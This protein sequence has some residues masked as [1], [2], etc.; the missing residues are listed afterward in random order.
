MR[1]DKNKINKVCV[2]CSGLKGDLFMKIP[3]IEAIK[4]DM[5]WVSISAVV[6]ENNVNVLINHPDITEVLPHSR[7]KKN[8]IKYLINTFK[9]IHELRKRK[10]DLTIN[11]YSGGISN[12]LV[13]L[14]NARYRIGFNHI[15]A[16]RIANNILIDLPDMHSNHWTFCLAKLL[17]PLGIE[18]SSVT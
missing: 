18:P 12:L 10:F 17:E 4:K 11:F 16:L 13:R 14:T 1:I 9:N 8:K 6:D 15:K 7:D 3:L 5:P 2:I